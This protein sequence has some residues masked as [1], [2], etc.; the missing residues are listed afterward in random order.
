MARIVAKK[1]PR[2]LYYYV[3]ESVI[4]CHGDFSAADV[5]TG[6]KVRIAAMHS[7]EPPRTKER[8]L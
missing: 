5:E 6:K 7:H 1:N 4:S 8:M 2:Y 3:W